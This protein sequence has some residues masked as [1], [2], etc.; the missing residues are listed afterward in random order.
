[1]PYT[2]EQIKAIGEEYLKKIRDAGYEI[3]DIIWSTFPR[4]VTRAYGKCYV[5]KHGGPSKIQINQ[6][7]I[8]EFD[9]REVI[10]HELVHAIKTCHGHHHD[11]VWKSTAYKVCTEV[12]GLKGGY[13]R[14]DN[15]ELEI[16][17]FIVFFTM[18]PEGAAVQ[19]RREFRNTNK[20]QEVT[21]YSNRLKKYKKLEKDGIIKI[22][23]IGDKP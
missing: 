12:L 14:T 10:A 21:V 16:D 4:K 5:D 3:T 20:L 15:R 1:M 7:I 23:A 22:H 19:K 17:K 9:I 2:L 8:N 11:Q 13:S 6:F 18:T